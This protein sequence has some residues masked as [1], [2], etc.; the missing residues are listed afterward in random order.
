[1]CGFAGVLTD[2]GLARDELREHAERMAATLRHRGPDDDGA[3]VDESSGIA[4]GFR[5][6]SIIDLSRLGHQPMHSLTGR[7]T[8]V[9]NGEV[10]NYRELRADL[11]REGVRFRG[12]S[13]TEVLLEAFEA[14]GAERTLNRANGMFA[15]ALWDSRDRTLTLARDRL[16]IKPL[17]V[18]WRSGFLL[19][20]SEL[21]ALL[22]GPGFDRTVDRDA[23]TS[24]FR[25]L[26][27]PAPLSIFRGVTKLLPGHFT[28]VRDVAVAPEPRPYWS[29]EEVADGGLRDPFQGSAEQLVE[30]ADRVLRNAVTRRLVA[31][32]PLGAFLS[33]GID[34]S[35]V[36]ALM[37]GGATERVRTFA[38]AF[39]EAEHNE[40][41]HAAR[42]ADHLGTD[43]TEFTLTADETRAV[44][45]QLG[46]VFDEPFASS[47]A[48][49]NFLLC[50]M[51]RGDVTVALSGTGG[52]E[53]FAGYNRYVYGAGLMRWV[54][55]APFPVRRM[56]GRVLS[57]ASV[58]AWERAYRW[59]EPA[60]P[61][62]LRHRLP[63]EKVRKLGDALSSRSPTE[64]YRS[65]VSAWQRPEEIVRAGSSPRG[66]WD[67]SIASESFH[68]T[69]F[70]RL[71][72]VDQLTYLPDDQ[73]AKVDRVSMAASL[74]VR[75]PILDHEVVEFAWR[76]PQQMKTRRGTG[77]WL[78]R[79][80]L[81]RHVPREL[82]D[83]PKVGLSVPLE[84]WLRG[85]LRSWADE[86]LAPDDLACDDLLDPDPIRSAWRSL[87]EGR[88]P[89][90]LALWAVIM[91]Q[92]WRSH[93]LS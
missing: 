26:H 12:A 42:V 17:F 61:K 32:V 34:S 30:E 69:W 77:K 22:A 10:Y 49:P 44:V 53:V 18:Y 6:L 54:G 57:A 15:L 80:V 48:I 86:L 82:V 60:L 78:L 87:Q 76:L 68:G 66:R 55:R 5:R 65:L 59:T 38:I 8:L 35:L 39:E 62:A 91:F 23:L 93:W 37:R 31:D 7:H 43:H 1:M 24:Y 88:G 56:V 52:D 21:K 16:G 3:W 36:V 74:E 72:L 50:K 2:T 83:R 81:Y 4:F 13:D 51:A 14:W 9:F 29:L 46:R 11:E 84:D 89:S 25:Y 58:D 85:P 33:G 90:P 45:P 79:E 64:L 27:V 70:D 19:F 73:L 92:L 40:A 20:G 41:A 71:L 75:V 67:A 28:V 47:S 63:G